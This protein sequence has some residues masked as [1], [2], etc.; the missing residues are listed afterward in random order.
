MYS[1]D[2]FGEVAL[3]N[4]SPRTATCVAYGGTVKCLALSREALQKI[5]GNQLEHIIE[6]NTAL[7]APKQLTK[8]STANICLYMFFILPL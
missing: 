5:L 1:G 3:L 6:K 7:E 4:N 8:M 2:Y